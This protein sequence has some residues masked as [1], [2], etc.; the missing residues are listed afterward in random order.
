MSVTVDTVR[1]QLKT[2]SEPVPDFLELPWSTPLAEWERERFVRVPR[3]QHRHVVRFVEHGRTVFALKEMPAHLA[4][5]E[6]RLLDV[7]REL[8]L[9]AVS[10]VGV[11][12]DR[13]DPG[14]EPLESV[15]ITR[16]LAY[17]LPYRRLFGDGVTT[18]LR[19]RL[20]DALAGLLVR[21][22]LEG[23][24]WGDCSLNN[25]LFRRDA[26]ALSA[27]VVDVETGE[28]HPGRL[29]DGQ[30]RLDLDVTA[31]NIVGGLLDLE[32]AGRLAEGVD[33]VDVADELTSRY[34][35]LWDELHR[36]DAMDPS[37]AWRINQRMSRLNELGFDTAEVEVQRDAGQNR[38]LFRPR[39]VEEGHHSRHLRQLTGIEAQ[40]NQARRL[41]NALN[42]YGAWLEDHGDRK[43]P[44][45]VRAYLWLQD[46]YEPTLAAIP[47]E[48]RGR[49]EDAEVYHQVL[50]HVWY[51]SEQQGR[52]VPLSEAVADYVDGVLRF[53]TD[54]R[55]L[56][57]TTTGEI[58]V[59][60]TDGH[61]PN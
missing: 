58:P 6:Y 18:E 33:P 4:D 30:R 36:V 56:L 37:E 48:L 5:R 51:L 14:G 27:Y 55:T 60:E 8:E 50:E 13:R 57:E 2:G 28:H 3:G 16:H 23:F 19:D 54:E 41:L 52:E 59:A 53:Q 45:A 32:A 31:V 12:H 44:E 61:K 9:P 25:A 35:G 10:L 49:L 24:F 1:L 22:H 42:S 17:S 43:L 29:T 40:E 39:V 26:G 47:A 38:I 20:V 34:E 7:L 46:R 15:L 11:A 21:L